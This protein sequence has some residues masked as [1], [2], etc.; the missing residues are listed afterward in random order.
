MNTSLVSGLLITSALIF[1]ACST[2]VKKADIANT[3]NPQQEII[4]LETD[5]LAA[6]AQNIDVLAPDEYKDSSKWFEEA[7]TDLASK[8]NQEEI[9]DDVR[10]GRGYLE[11]AHQVASNR[12]QKAPGLFEARQAAFKAGA[13]KHA[14]LKSDLKDVDSD[15][16]DKAADLTSLS[17]EKI[18]K[19]QERYV[20]LE[21]K[22][23]VLTQLGTSQAKFNGA[24][25]D[26]AAKK[27]PQTFKKAEL[28]LNNAES[29]ISA[30]V[31]SPEGYRAAVGTAITD[32]RLLSEVMLTIQQNGKNLSEGAA[33][34]MVSQNKQINALNTDLSTSQAESAASKSAMNEK[35][36]ALNQELTDKAQELTDKSQE[37]TEQSKVLDSANATVANQKA[38][39]AARAQFSP[40]EAEAYQQG[41]N[42]LIRLKKVNFA[43][44]RSD[45]PGASLEVLAK[46]SSVAKSMNASEIKVEGHTDSIGSES[47]NKVISEQR[48]SAVASYF[49]SN[50]FNE[51][52]SEGYG[53]QK[54]IATNKSKEGRAQNR[55]VDIIIK[56][57]NSTV[58]Q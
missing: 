11:K 16:A 28:S 34:K 21:R 42:L 27:A 46:V 53:F 17:S 1:T 29:V 8:Q 32:T 2:N 56:P 33:L 23:T 57:D 38:M 49:K 45:L 19:L 58:A 41:E 26:G 12:A 9:L 24:K 5:L 39:E 35:N 18:S 3:A 31:R 52:T 4:R 6:S 30:N 20:T 7:K 13:N 55:R 43:S 44:G 25:K 54:P 50:G 48:A 40:D 51:V 14:E 47:Q 37:M 22:A 36:Q 10:K 15:V